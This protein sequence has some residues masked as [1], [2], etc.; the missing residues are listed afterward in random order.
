LDRWRDL[1]A[2]DRAAKQQAV[3]EALAKKAGVNLPSIV[4]GARHPER[5]RQIDEGLAE[6]EAAATGLANQEKARLLRMRGRYRDA[7]EGQLAGPGDPKQLKFR[8]VVSSEGDAIPGKCPGGLRSGF[9][10]PWIGP[11]STATAD[12]VP[13]T[14]APGTWLHPFIDIKSN[15]CDDT[16]P[17]KTVQ[18]LEYRLDAPATTFGVEAVRVD[19]IATGVSS[20]KLGDT[21]WFS[22]PDP[23]YDHTRV[24]LDVFLGQQVGAESSILPLVSETLFAGHGGGARQ[25]RS[26]LSAE[27]YKFNFFAQGADIGGGDLVCLVQVSCSALAIGSHAKVRLDFSTAQELGIFVGGVALIGIYA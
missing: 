14:D 24:Q 22:S 19:L 15:S 23:L 27:T 18:D 5:D 4:E 25:I 3:L 10:S 13:S 20:A 6:L 21:G 11:D 1:H 7:F 2:A 9:F 16:G 8:E 17:G 12:I 26:I